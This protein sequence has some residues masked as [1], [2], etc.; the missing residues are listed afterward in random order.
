MRVYHEGF[1]M[2]TGNKNRTVADVKQS[3]AQSSMSS[4]LGYNSVINKYYFGPLNYSN[5]S[6][7]ADYDIHLNT[8]RL[9]HQPRI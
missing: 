8:L 7:T 4:P 6:G 1:I 5:N 2:S 9:F 3:F